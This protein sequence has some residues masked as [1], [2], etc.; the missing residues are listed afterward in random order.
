MKKRVYGKVVSQAEKWKA[1]ASQNAGMGKWQAIC[2]KVATNVALRKVGKQNSK[3]ATLGEKQRG[4]RAAR[5]GENS[6][7]PY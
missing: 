1:L 6:E 4:E 2:N 5:N 7:E 3:A